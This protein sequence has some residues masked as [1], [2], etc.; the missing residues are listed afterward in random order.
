MCTGPGN[1]CFVVS[2]TTVPE[3]ST[4]GERRMVASPA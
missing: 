1:G 2:S 3:N 4:S